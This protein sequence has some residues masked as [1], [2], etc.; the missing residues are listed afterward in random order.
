[1]ERI[2]VRPA[3]GQRYSLEIRGHELVV[4]QPADAGGTDTAPT[5][6][7]LFVAGLASCIAFYAGRY[8]DRHGVCSE[9]LLVDTEWEFAEGRPARVGT[10]RIVV[11]PPRDLPEE[12]LPGF[13]AV[14]RH[15]TVHNSL[16]APPEI[17]VELADSSVAA[18]AR[19]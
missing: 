13:L 6:T 11:T 9:G 7:E 15:C 14:A 3:G 2:V 12:R 8:L 16:E 5:P 17:A 1:M 19:G 4:D 10:I 18:P